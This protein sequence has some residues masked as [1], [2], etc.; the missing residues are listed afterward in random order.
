[1]NLLERILMLS[2]RTKLILC[3][4]TSGLYLLSFLPAYQAVGDRAGILATLPVFMMSSLFGLQSGLIASLVFLPVNTI[5]MN[6]AGEAG[7]TAS[8]RDGSIFGFIA[9]VVTAILIGYLRDISLQLREEVKNRMLAEEEVRQLNQTLELRVR[10]KTVELLEANAALKDEITETKRVRDD[11]KQAEDFATTV[12]SSVN[13]GI[14]VFDRKMRYIVWNEFMESLTGLSADKVLDHYVSD[15]FPFIKEQGIDRMIKSALEGESVKSDV[16]PYEVPQ[17]GKSGWAS[18]AYSP[19]KDTNGEIIGAVAVIRD[20]TESKLTQEH[21]QNQLTR[22]KALRQIQFAASASLDM[23]VAFEVLLD[24]VTTKLGVDAATILLFDPISHKL[25]YAGGRGFRTDALK[26]TQLQ[27]GEGFAGRA[28]LERRVIH[29]PDLTQEPQGFTRSP[30]F[31]AE[32]FISYCAVPLITKAQVRGILELFG[33]HPRECDEEWFTFLETLGYDAAIAIDNSKL[34]EDLQRANTDLRRAY[35]NSL[36]GWARALDLRDK[37]TEGHTQRVTEFT[38]R[39]AQE[40]GISSETLVNIRR[41]ALL[42]DIGKIAIP[43][44]ILLKP[45]PLTDE[46]WEIMRK[47]PKYAYDLIYPIEFLRPAIDIPYS[48]HEKWDGTGYPRGLR[49]EAIPLAS[50]IFAVIDVWDALNSDRPYRKAWPRKKII[51]HIREQS[52]KHFD[53]KVVE[54]FLELEPGFYSDMERSETINNE[55]VLA[56]VAA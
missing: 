38:T 2:K 4:G 32:E 8:I 22:L 15:Q 6:L 48:H 16:L 17:T 41:G 51:D 19:L 26:H 45:G 18:S 53:P 49:G 7:F 35:D 12:I 54:V 5:L 10:E 11:L 31:E 25:R 14:I 21:I 56:E 42:H 1:L 13:D 24:Q 55:L 33:R 9:L 47:H 40:M 23:N 34:F 50:R 37:E 30:L 20:M 27:V 39:L 44:S 28:V 52:G 29:I 43:D 46:E 36:E 3:V